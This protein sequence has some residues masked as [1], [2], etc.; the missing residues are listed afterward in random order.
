MIAATSA[1]FV[2]TAYLVIL[3][4]QCFA[5]SGSTGLY[6]SACIKPS[7][8]GSYSISKQCVT[9]RLYDSRFFSSSSIAKQSSLVSNNAF[10]STIQQ[11]TKHII[12]VLLFSSLKRKTIIFAHAVV[13]ASLL[14]LTSSREFRIIISKGILRMKG[15]VIYL[16]KI[17]RSNEATYLNTENFSSVI[18]LKK[19]GIKLARI[20]KKLKEE[21]RAL[22]S[23]KV[24]EEKRAILDN[25]KQNELIRYTTATAIMMKEA[26]AR[27]E[28]DQKIINDRRMLS[29]AWTQDPDDFPVTSRCQK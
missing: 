24:N 2:L 1:I 8:I 18:N 15:I 27:E 25:V 16:N 21:T 17:I 22:I 11:N 9:T 29:L 7:T 26:A 12:K 20:E 5:F 6:Q 23:A 28:R 14:R 19:E 4:H 10:L 3:P 13:I